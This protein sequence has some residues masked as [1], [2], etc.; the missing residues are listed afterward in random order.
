MT[1]NM[2]SDLLTQH[3]CRACQA[4]DG[5]LLQRAKWNLRGKKYVSEHARESQ[6]WHAPER[7][8][9]GADGLCGH[10]RVKGVP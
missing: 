9:L 7:I 8:A 10:C 6:F 5:G 2:R 3:Q 1:E 4:M